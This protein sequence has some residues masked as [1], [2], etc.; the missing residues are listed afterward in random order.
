MQPILDHMA[1]PV[2]TALRKYLEAERVLTEALE[3]K[4]ASAI[5]AARADVMLAGRQAV[6]LLH[7]FADFALKE[8]SA[9]LPMFARIDD[10]R[11]A[12][13]AKCVYGRSGEY[14]DDVGLLRDVADAF[15]HHKPDR[16]NSRVAISTD[17]TPIGSGYGMLRYGEGKYGGA[18]QVVMTTRGGDKRALSS[19]LQNV[20]DAWMTPLPPISRF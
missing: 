20:F 12:V 1:G 3:S 19:V 2:R 13:D 11:T 10:V 4:D 5:A 9:A 18:E 17:V 7:H 6:D 14:I 16:A 15:K 8:P